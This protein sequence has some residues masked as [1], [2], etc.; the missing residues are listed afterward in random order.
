MTA[1]DADLAPRAALGQLIGPVRPRLLLAVAMGAASAAMRVAALVLSG[2][3][4]R[5]LLDGVE[6]G[7]AALWVI[8]I[9]AAMA[10]SAAL[11]T[12]AGATSHH[13]A[14]DHE[15]MM[16]RAI[17]THLGK[18]PLGA[19][20]RI[21]AGGVKK[22]VQGDVRAMHAA[23]AD[24]PPMLGTA[25]GGLAASLLAIGLIEWRLLLVVLAVLPVAAIVMSVA[26]R[27]YATERAAYD[28]ALEAID[29][30]S[31]E[32]VQGMQEVLTFDGGSESFGRFAESVR[33]FTTSVKAW[34]DKT[35]TGSLATRLLIAPLP[36]TIL[37]A[38][39]G[40]A[41]VI[42]GWIDPVA[43]VVALL[44]AAMPMDSF[45]PLMYM[46]EHN[47]RATAAAARIT[48]VLSEPP[49]PEPHALRDGGVRRRG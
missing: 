41:M 34:N 17:T 43:V 29:A 31:V 25:L 12:L 33:A 28:A 2:L 39:L 22:I 35:R 20:Q 46:T 26:M 42:A 44:L 14:F 32:Y 40:T 9:V 16:R 48:Q 6:A 47:N 21:G 19:V 4:V 3:L 5:R 49:L 24:S 45:M 18:L 23:I 36:V 27:D 11:T 13:A 10:A 15:V 38:G 7:E 37:V 30:A 8:A 1:P